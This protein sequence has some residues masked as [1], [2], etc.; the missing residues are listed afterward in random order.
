M[1]IQ[2][3]SAEVKKTGME[4]EIVELSNLI[5]AGI[6]I[7]LG[8][9]SMDKVKLLGSI[10]AARGRAKQVSVKVGAS[11]VSYNAKQGQT[12][13]GESEKRAYVSDEPAAKFL[14]WHK[15]LEK[16]HKDYGI[17]YNDIVAVPASLVEF[18]SKHAGK[19][20]ASAS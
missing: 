11:S 8:V 12:T 15:G 20:S 13:M 18:L 19:A 17:P 4:T 2:T 10:N 6:A 9:P 16:F 14:A 3:T 1:S 5:L 7:Q